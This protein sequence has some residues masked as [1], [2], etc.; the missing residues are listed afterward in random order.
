[1]SLCVFRA[2]PV[3]SLRSGPDRSKD[4]DDGGEIVPCNRLHLLEHTRHYRKNEFQ[5]ERNGKNLRERFVGDYLEQ[6]SQ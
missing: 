4:N 2:P 1:V 5:K 6:L 3:E